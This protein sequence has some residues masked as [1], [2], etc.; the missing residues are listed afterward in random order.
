MDKVTIDGE[1]ADGITRASLKESIDI[2]KTSISNLS[3][4]KKHKPYQIEEFREN[5]DMLDAL[6]K[7]YGYY[8]G[9]YK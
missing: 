4:I 8:G 6:T 9:N 1:T 3:K 2:L 7:V 5:T